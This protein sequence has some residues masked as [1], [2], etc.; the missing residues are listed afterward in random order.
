[1]RQFQ[2]PVRLSP[3]RSAPSR[4]SFVICR[5]PF[6]GLNRADAVSSG[7]RLLESD[8]GR[9]AD[10]MEIPKPSLAKR[11]E[12]LVA[13][14]SAD[15]RQGGALSREC[16][17]RASRNTHLPLLHCERK[18]SAACSTRVIRQ[19]C[20]GFSR[21]GRSRKRLVLALEKKAA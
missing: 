10:G 5:K 13:C 8:R 12:E 17:R 20:H 19:S 11:G 6:S 15:G 2:Y 7:F 4:S 9:I 14:S 18:K 1:M 3:E 16:A 21:P